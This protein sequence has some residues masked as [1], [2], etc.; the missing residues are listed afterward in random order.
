MHLCD[1]L[2]FPVYLLRQ[3]CFNAFDRAADLDVL[4][5]PILNFM[6]YLVRSKILELILPI[7]VVIIVIAPK[8]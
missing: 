8:N 2:Y 3:I 4:D 1:N 5:H 6:Y 7:S